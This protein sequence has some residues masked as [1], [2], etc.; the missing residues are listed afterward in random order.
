[1][2]KKTKAL[3]AVKSTRPKLTRAL[4]IGD[5]VFCRSGFGWYDGD[6]NWISNADQV[7]PK[8]LGNPGPIPRGKCPN[9]DR[10]CFSPCCT[11]LFYYVVSFIDEDPTR[12]G[13]RRYHLITN[14]MTRSH[15]SGYTFDDGGHFSPWLVEDP[16][17]Y[18][19]NTSKELLGQAADHLL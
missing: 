2:K 18:I 6:R 17:R 11:F 13:R 7:D 10:N 12:A 5:I 14:A 19:L 1:M 4:S 8:G 15:R 3:P 9:G 16:P